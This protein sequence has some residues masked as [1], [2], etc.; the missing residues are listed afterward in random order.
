MGRISSVGTSFDKLQ[1]FF[2]TV[3]IAT[4]QDGENWTMQAAL[5]PLEGYIRFDTAEFG[6]F[7][8]FQKT[9]F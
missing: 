8:C 4:G 1:F 9:S 5:Q 2:L 6:T 3:Q 7:T